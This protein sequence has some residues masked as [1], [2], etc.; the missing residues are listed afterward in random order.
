MGK[1]NIKAKG[2][3]ELEKKFQEAP[4][5]VVPCMKH[6]VYC[7]G[8]V[9]LEEVKRMLR[10]AMLGHG[11]PYNTKHLIDSY[12]I[13]K[14]STSMDAVNTVAHFTDYDSVQTKWTRRTGKPGNPQALKA[15]VL[16]SGKSEPNQVAAT[17]FYSKAMRVCRNRAR[18]QMEDGFN[19]YF[20]N[21][22]KGVK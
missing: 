6:G 9:V 15:A 12:I 22:L 11:K 19:D 13:S 3:E 17:H 7:G 2:F 16:E 10:S 8:S 20:T 18:K 4:K 5:K 1:Y 21:A 14:M